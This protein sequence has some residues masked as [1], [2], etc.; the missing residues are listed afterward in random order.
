MLARCADEVYRSQKP[1]VDVPQTGEWDRV[2]QIA[3]PLL[4]L[5]LIQQAPLAVPSKLKE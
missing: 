4:R 2:R 5:F 1:K 3:I